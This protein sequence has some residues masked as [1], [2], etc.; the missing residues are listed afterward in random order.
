MH[1][2]SPHYWSYLVIIGKLIGFLGLTYLIIKLSSSNL[3]SHLNT[4]ARTNTVCVWVWVSSLI[5]LKNKF[6]KVSITQSKHVRSSFEMSQ[7]AICC[8]EEN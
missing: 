5:G 8:H 2:S 1:A 4:A 7:V 3:S 6:H